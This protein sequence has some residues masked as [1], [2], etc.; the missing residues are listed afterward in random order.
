MFLG[1][2]KALLGEAGVQKKSNST[3]A[4]ALETPLPLASLLLAWVALWRLRLCRWVCSSCLCTHMLSFSRGAP[5][6]KYWD[7]P[8]TLDDF[9]ALHCHPPLWHPDRATHS[10]RY[11]P[12]SAMMLCY[13]ATMV[14][15]CQNI[16]KRCQNSVLVSS[17][18]KKSPAKYSSKWTVAI[19]CLYVCVSASVVPPQYMWKGSRSLSGPHA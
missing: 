9:G 17:I 11:A 8:L 7:C 4:G 5:S 16:P 10:L 6:Q 3:W 19:Q 14:Q 13:C 15:R 18:W 1:Y 12:S 2:G